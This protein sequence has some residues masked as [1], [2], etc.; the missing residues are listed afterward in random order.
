MFECSGEYSSIFPCLSSLPTVG[1]RRHSPNVEQPESCLEYIFLLGADKETV[2]SFFW[3][4]GFSSYL[5]QCACFSLNPDR[6]HVL[7]NFSDG[8]IVVLDEY[9]IIVQNQINHSVH[10]SW[11]S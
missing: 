1:K 6:L 5:V 7:L 4:D 9:A 11:K 10:I 2:L 3:N 8:G